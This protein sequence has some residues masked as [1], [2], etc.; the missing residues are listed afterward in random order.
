MANINTND[1]YGSFVKYTGNTGQFTYSYSSLT[2]NNSV[3]DQDQL[4]ILRQHTPTSTFEAA[5]TPD[6]LGGT[7][8]TGAEQWEV[9]S[10]PNDSSS[11]SS[12]YTID[13]TS[14]TI[15]L[16]STAS[17][18]VWDRSG[19]SINLPVFDPDNDTLIIVRKTHGVN[20]FVSW[21]SGSR[22]TS[23]QLNHET[24]QL[25]N[26]TQEI[27]D[28]I[29]KTTDLNPF[30]GTADGICP[31]SSTGKISSSYI[32]STSFDLSDLYVYTG[33]GLT[34]GDNLG[35]S[36]T[37]SIDLHS[38]TALSF[39]SGELT[40]TLNSNHLEF[41]SNVLD[42]KLKSSGGLLAD[43]TGIYVDLTDSTTTDD[44]TKALS[45][46]GGK[47]IQDS[48]DLYGSGIVYL[49]EF[50]PASPP[51]P[52]TLEAGMTYD[53]ID[54]G[55]TASPF[56][57]DA[58]ATIAVVTGDFL[59][60]KT[61]GD[62]G[63][64]VAKPPT[65]N[66]L[67]A[68]FRADGATAATGDF[69]LDSNKITS[70]GEPAAST[71]AATMNYVDSVKVEDLA[72]TSGSA[73]EGTI[74]RHD[75][76]D[77]VMALSSDATDG[78]ALEDL[79][80]TSFTDVGANDIL[81]YNGST[82]KWENSASFADPQSFYSGGAGDNAISGGLTG[83]YGDGSTVEFTLGEA[84]NTTASA[85]VIVNIDGVTQKAT[86]YSIS[87]S[88]LT[89]DTAPPHSSEIYIV[90]FGLAH[91][92]D[93]SSSYVTSTGSTTGRTLATRF[94]E[95]VNVKDYGAVG[96]G[97]T[98]DTTAIQA[99][100]SAVSVSGGTLFFPTGSYKVTS[101]ISMTISE[102]VHIAGYNAKLVFSGLSAGEYALTLQ[103]SYGSATSITGLTANERA[104]TTTLADTLSKGDIIRVK[105]SGRRD[106]AAGITLSAVTL[107]TE[108]TLTAD[109]SVFTSTDVGKSIIP[110]SGGG[111]V[112]ITGY[113]SGTELTGVVGNND[114][115]GSLTYT[116]GSWGFTELFAPSRPS[117]IKGEFLTID[118]ANTSTDELIF[119]EPLTTTYT[120]SYTYAETYTG[121]SL[122][123]EGLQ[124]ECTEDV[125]GLYLYELCDVH[126]KD[127][128]V[129]GSSMR[130]GIFLS[131]TYNANI[132]N[133]TING[134]TSTT[135]PYGLQ[136][137]SSQFV[138]TYGLKI[139]SNGHGITHSGGHPS[140]YCTHTNA[141][142][143]GTNGAL[144]LHG[145]ADEITVRDSRMIGGCTIYGRNCSIHNCTI[146]DDLGLG[147]ESTT[148]ANELIRYRPESAGGR[149]CL[150]DCNIKAA[151][152]AEWDEDDIAS[153]PLALID[154]FDAIQVAK[155]FPSGSLESLVIDNCSV[156]AFRY[157]FFLNNSTKADYGN[158]TLDY[159]TITNSKL[160]STT[161]NFLRIISSQGYPQIK[162]ICLDN[163]IGITLGA[164]DYTY[165]P[166]PTEE[167]PVKGFL[168]KPN[169]A[170][171]YASAGFG[172]DLSLEIV[173]CNFSIDDEAHAETG[174]SYYTCYVKS[175]SMINNKFK[176]G[177]HVRIEEADRTT[178]IGNEFLSMGEYNG[179]YLL[180]P[181]NNN[182]SYYSYSG[183]ISID[184]LGTWNNGQANTRTYTG[185][186]TIN[187]KDYGATGDG[188]TDDTTA[189]QAAIDVA[190]AADGGEIYF[191]KGIYAISSTLE[192]AKKGISLIGSSM[193][194]TD[195]VI[196][197][198]KTGGTFTDDIML[199]LNI[200]KSDTTTWVDAYPNFQSGEIKNIAFSN[201][202]SG[203]VI[204]GLKAIKYSGSHKFENIHFRRFAKSIE[205]ASG[206]YGDTV[207]IER[208]AFT[209]SLDA[210]NYQ[211]DLSGLGDCFVLRQLHFSSTL[212]A[213]GMVYGIRLNTATGGNLS[214][215]IG[216]KH[217]LQNVTGTEFHTSHIEV[218]YLL[219]DDSTISIHDN[220]FYTEE[221][222]TGTGSEAGTE[223]IV[224]TSS[225]GSSS[226]VRATLSLYDNIFIKM[227]NS[228]S[229][230]D[231]TDKAEI[232]FNTYWSVYLRNNIRTISES[233]VVS[234]RYQTVID[235]AKDDNTI[236]DDWRNH[237][238]FLNAGAWVHADG[239]V[240]ITGH[241]RNLSVTFGGFT[242]VTTND[243]GV[244][245]G[246]TDTYYYQA[247]LFTDTTRL[248]G[249]VPT[250]SE[251]S[252]AVTNGGDVPWLDIAL[253]SVDYLGGFILRVYRGTSTGSY[254][255]YVDIPLWGCDILVD[256]GN[257]I[258]GYAWKSRGAA[259]IDTLTTGNSNIATWTAG[260]VQASGA[261][262][263]VIT[264]GTWKA[265]DEYH[266][267]TNTVSGG[268]LTL[269][270]RRLTSGSDHVQGTD[271]ALLRI[272]HDAP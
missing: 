145:A 195:G 152:L 18:Y 247:Q 209:E 94:A 156:S 17:D 124:I 118:T 31:L 123:L 38:D 196:L 48:I 182:Q 3:S 122:T 228:R 139:S 143:S 235:I 103:G 33:D 4:V 250:S 168:I 169:D 26:L 265:G 147:G 10:L 137:W 55:T 160:T 162:R 144:D 73:A 63:W 60:Y 186:G 21:S 50:D 127:C 243:I 13:D 157:P 216:G 153:T 133:T 258:N 69:D 7:K 100:I 74:L 203:T 240:D 8:I 88:T 260:R 207:T 239:I 75:G 16:S 241:T 2:L 20:P 183:N 262:S 173:N 101:E 167:P 54:D 194:A 136:V 197:L 53:V 213:G 175:V 220:T 112:Y 107:T 179:F 236:V 105:E 132:Y 24:Q 189:I 62:D 170:T 49:G 82:S 181:A 81:F 259:A 29:F 210:T 34:G 93:A 129:S 154:Q 12:M 146:S 130:K 264:N 211:V 180:N 227:P 201:F 158:L 30:Y 253:G 121:G 166:E 113:T 188:V 111:T 15:T 176:N 80:D 90:V 56:L 204:T 257:V 65:T 116:S 96:D 161:Q 42:I 142:I 138:N 217:S 261:A 192:V 214:G 23:S 149:M 206:D 268:W 35:D 22:L 68:Y 171:N 254:D 32:D 131:N 64:Y 150:T 141:E 14:K 1:E 39:T 70:L 263:V 252:V 267:I 255:K 109:A 28:K 215:I 151:D 125:T 199:L 43:S 135:D 172:E 159:I 185:S 86:D 140:R 91:T 36:I 155:N 83:G 177:G 89:F 256:D 225:S 242:S 134:A 67:S 97:V 92:G 234:R 51:T 77:W 245:A 218:G 98:D 9:W 205:K 95:V 266:N 108:I 44:S 222:S 212:D 202:N 46:A 270:A 47:T 238:H 237:A 104:G 229:G 61:E 233:G 164:L 208:C 174:A 72:D 246:A 232:A 78:L 27:H 224:L 58:S 219:L 200:A 114:A 230:F 187:V 106:P 110:T 85:S 198:S 184:C 269:G 79:N 11:G 148:V 221:D 223:A 99:A 128:K 244:F 87:G 84:P 66:D 190:E 19:T 59:R 45:A 126:I 163:C 120:D 40:I 193:D 165:D 115:M 41:A 231:S 191:P 52:P 119:D 71:D 251:V 37:L 76:T 25:L 6:G 248:L 57:D 249:R 102:S 117:Y 271:W 272:K 178:I 5:S 226:A